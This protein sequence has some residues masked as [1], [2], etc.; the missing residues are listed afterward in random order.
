ML[1]ASAFNSFLKTLEEPP[2]HAI[3]I[4]ATT[5]KQKIIPT[6]LSRC[7]IFDFNR[8]KVDDIVMH[9]EY[10]AEKEKIDYEVEALGVIAQRSDGGLRDALSVF[11]QISSFTENKITYDK[12]SDNNILITVEFAGETVVEIGSNT[13]VHVSSIFTTAG[14]GVVTK[15]TNIAPNSAT[16]EGVI[17]DEATIAEIF[18]TCP[19]TSVLFVVK[20]PNW[21]WAL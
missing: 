1:S 18:V 10:V 9:L 15:T 19:G 8:I 11:D 13:T 16:N 21:P 20:Y 5:E 14:S 2:G 3:F 7:Q 4:L 12:V 17:G 6:I